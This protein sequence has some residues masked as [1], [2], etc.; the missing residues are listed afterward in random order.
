LGIFVS[1]IA[2]P[3]NGH[4]SPILAGPS[5]QIAE[6]PG[7]MQKRREMQPW[8]LQHQGTGAGERG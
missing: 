5:F 7:L 2:T 3:V 4:G 6:A 1:S 8:S